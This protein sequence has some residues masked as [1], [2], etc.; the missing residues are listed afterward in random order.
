M[1]ATVVSPPSASSQRTPETSPQPS[2]ATPPI[3]QSVDFLVIGSGIAGLTYALHAAQYGSVLI[4]TKKDRAESNTNYA[5]GGIAGVM[6]ED[7][8][9][10]SH[11]H[12]TLVAGAGLCHEDAVSVLVREGPDRIRDLIA[13]GA[14]FS[15]HVDASGRLVLELGREGGHTRNRIVHAVDRTGWECERTLLRH[16]K[17]TPSIAI[18]EHLFALDLVVLNGRC[19]G[20]DVLDAATGSVHRIGAR[21]VLLA[22]GGCGQVYLHTTNPTV[23]TGDGVAMAWRAGATIANMEFIQFHP[24]SLFHPAGESFLISEA[25]RGEGGILRTADGATFMERYH[26]MGALAPRD[27]VARAIHAERLKRGDPCV[28]LDVTHLDADFL[29]GRFPTIYNRCLELGI[30]ITREPIPVVPAAHYMC[31]GVRT[32]L[33]GRTDVRGLYA[34]GEVACT[35]VHGANRLASNSLLEAMVFGRRAA[36]AAIRDCSSAEPAPAVPSQQTGARPPSPDPR[37]WMRRLKAVMHD[38][39]GIVRN[40]NDLKEA[41]EEASRTA[42]QAEVWIGRFRLTPEL[43]ELR[44]VAQVAHLIVRSALLRKESRGL[45]YTTDY[46]ETDDAGWKRDTLLSRG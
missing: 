30:D 13:L 46:P 5:Q 8:D 15:S 11:A 24:T 4:V 10:E 12:D 43:A 39:A 28:Y 31:G 16:V 20:V 6:T 17:D 42:E 21:A 22:T 26:P 23:A 19:C 37:E 34:A 27:I 1:N 18:L 44:N 36:D 25:V 33:D 38:K 32:D 3:P 41:A 14:Q 45:H 9:V 7:D 29:R 35:G 2:A 40:D